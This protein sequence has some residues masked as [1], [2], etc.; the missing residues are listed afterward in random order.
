MPARVEHA[1][2]G[3]LVADGALAARAARRLALHALLHRLHVRR[4]AG[5][6]HRRRHVGRDR[7]VDLI[8]LRLRDGR[9]RLLGARR[10]EARGRLVDGLLRVLRLDDG[11]EQADG[12]RAAVHVE[13]GPQRQGDVDVHEEGGRAA[14]AP[15]RHLAGVR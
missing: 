6:E 10:R 2:D 11:A 3:A 7:L 8:G 15:H 4:R 12:P 5:R 13:D 1:V 9:Q 14:V